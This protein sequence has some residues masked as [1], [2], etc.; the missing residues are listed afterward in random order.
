MV[1]ALIPV[2]GATKAHPAIF[3]IKGKPGEK[4]AVIVT[5]DPPETTSTPTFEPSGGNAAATAAPAPT[6]TP[7]PAE[8]PTPEP[9]NTDLGQK[10]TV[11]VP[12]GQPPAELVRLQ[13]G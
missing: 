3:V 9:D 5:D 12:E 1:V 6:A 13:P 4:S 11:T 7:T 10:P 8:T 2:G